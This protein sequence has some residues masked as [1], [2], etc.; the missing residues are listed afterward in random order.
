MLKATRWLE[1]KIKKADRF[2]VKVGL[3][4]KGD[5]EIK[6]LL[7]GTSSLIV[8]IILAIYTIVLIIQLASKEGS[9]ING[10]QKV[11]RLIYDPTVYT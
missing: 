2:G 9:I 4:F 8:N 3:N 10:G 5:T 6:T 1:N 7:G 11:R